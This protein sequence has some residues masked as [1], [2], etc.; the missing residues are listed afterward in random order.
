MQ[1]PKKN[2]ITSTITALIFIALCLQ[3]GCGSG[4]SQVIQA[5]VAKK[6]EGEKVADEGRQQALRDL[7]AGKLR[8]H[9]Y[10]MASM[11]R[12][13]YRKVL[14]D[15]YNVKL[16]A[17]AGC[18]LSRGLKAHTKAYNKVMFDAIVKR[19]GSDALAKARKKANL[20]RFK[21]LKRL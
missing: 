19:F 3:A 15:L 1:V 7:A 8:I 21:R 16:V 9:T 4:P 11:R 10:G 18:L 5:V 20:M 12:I 6:S 13:H 17:V 14:L 2:I